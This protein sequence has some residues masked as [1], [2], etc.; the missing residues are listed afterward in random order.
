MIAEGVVVRVAA[1]ADRQRDAGVGQPLVAHRT[2]CHAPGRPTATI[3]CSSAFRAERIRHA[4]ADN[5]SREHVDDEGDVDEAPPRRDVGEVRDP[6]GR[7]SDGRRSTGRSHRCPPAWWSPTHGLGQPHGGPSLASGGPPYSAPRGPRVAVA[8]RPCIPAGC[9]RLPAP[10]VDPCAPSRG[11]AWRALC[12]K[13]GG[14][15]GTTVQIVDPA[16]WSSMIH[17]RGRRS[18]SACAKYADALRSHLCASAHDLAL[19]LLRALAFR[20]RQATAEP[21]I[22][23]GLGPTSGRFGRAPQ[24]RNRLD[25]GPLG[26]VLRTT[27]RTAEAVRIH[28]GLVNCGWR[29]LPRT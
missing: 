22:A 29:A 25:R 21:V 24:A 1:T 8:A 6:W 10:P 28:L 18:S 23:L 5:A 20:G 9:R 11:I 17:H 26:R 7:R 15:I 12:Q 3:A 16:R 13:Y 2:A 4:P 14:A 27:T 19:Q